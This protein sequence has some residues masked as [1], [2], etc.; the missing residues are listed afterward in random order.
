MLLA[1]VGQEL[2]RRQ[3]QSRCDDTLN[4]AR[5]EEEEEEEEEGRSTELAL[6]LFIHS[7]LCRLTSGML[8]RYVF[9]RTV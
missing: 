5:E 9:R 3:S 4:P 1:L 8:P 6:H 7:T 2:G